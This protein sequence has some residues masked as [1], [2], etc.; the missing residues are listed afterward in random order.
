[1]TPRHVLKGS[2]PVS[3]GR[4]ST[5]DPRHITTASY[6]P[7]SSSTSVI[8]LFTKV[9]FFLP[10]DVFAELWHARKSAWRYRCGLTFIAPG[11]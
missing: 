9:M 1:M 5:L 8:D 7:S 11:K 2:F 3:P 10:S 4:K 6:P